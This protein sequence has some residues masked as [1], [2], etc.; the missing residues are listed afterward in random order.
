[1][2]DNK[3]VAFS[4]FVITVCGQRFSLLCWHGRQRS[5]GSESDAGVRRISLGRCQLRVG[6]E[7]QENRDCWSSIEPIEARMKSHERKMS[8][9][10]RQRAQH[11]TSMLKLQ[12]GKSVVTS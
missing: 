12:S 11:I 3:N 9:Y 10:R 4:T 2:K 7:R 6:N 8:F 5:Y 1:M